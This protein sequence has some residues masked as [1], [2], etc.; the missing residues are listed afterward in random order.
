MMRLLK[1]LNE[2]KLFLSKYILT[3]FNNIHTTLIETTSIT[4]LKQFGIA[5]RLGKQSEKKIMKRHRQRFCLRLA[6]DF[7]NKST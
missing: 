7:P 5:P 4:A 3:Y 2:L 1:T 6:N